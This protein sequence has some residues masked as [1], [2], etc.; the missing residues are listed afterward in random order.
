MSSSF[1]LTSRTDVQEC[2]DYQKKYSIQ[3]MWL[4]TIVMEVA[5]SWFGQALAFVEELSSMSLTTER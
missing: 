1:A 4:S 3:T 5:Q 2:G